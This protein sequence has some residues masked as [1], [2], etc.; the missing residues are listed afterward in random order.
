MDRCEAVGQHLGDGFEVIGLE[1]AGAGRTYEWEKSGSG[2][3]FTKETL[4][5][6]RIF[7]ETR[8]WPRLVRLVGHSLKARIGH[9]FLCHYERPE[10]FLL[11]LLMRLLGR[12]V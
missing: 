7:E 12:R 11:A 2:E 6:G 4:L 9:L 8:F 3:N 10:I 5:P 1:I